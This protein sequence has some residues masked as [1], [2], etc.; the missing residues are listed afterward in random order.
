MPRSPRISSRSASRKPGLP[1]DASALQ[2]CI[3][4]ASLPGLP[5]PRVERARRVLLA[6]L[7][8]AVARG[9]DTDTLLRALASGLVARQIGDALR[10][11]MLENPPEVV[12]NAACASG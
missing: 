2:A 4:N 1:T 10:A 8:S 11:R 7:A 3:I 5:G 6:W 9:Q 12:R